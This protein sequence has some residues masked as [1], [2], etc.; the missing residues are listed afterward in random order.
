[1]SDD[2]AVPIQVTAAASLGAKS[3]SEYGLD[4]LE[5]FLNQ[6]H[7]VGLLEKVNDSGLILIADD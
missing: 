1:M 3:D 6:I 7:K 5:N 2:K 4:R